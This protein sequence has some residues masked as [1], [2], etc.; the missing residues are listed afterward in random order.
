MRLRVVR[1][2]RTTEVEVAADLA[3]VSV[4]GQTYP[5]TVVKRGP[6]RGELEIAGER[7]QIDGWPEHFPE[8]PSAVDVN[9]ERGP[10]TIER[11]GGAEAVPAPARAERPAPTVTSGPAAPSAPPPAGGVPV[12]PPMPGKVIELRVADG[13]RVEVGT[14]LLV[15]EA[16]KMRNEITSPATGVVRGLRVAAGA[17]ARAKEPM[18]F[19]APA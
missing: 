2:G 19:V 6:L 12:V 9:G 18:L 11:L 10:A 8:P 3:T 15:L 14:V 4:D 13:D 17:N 5:V 16:M 1:D 7:V